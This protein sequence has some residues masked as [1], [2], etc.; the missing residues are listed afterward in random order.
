MKQKSLT[1]HART[2]E[3]PILEA[4]EFGFAYMLMRH[5]QLHKTYPLAYVEQLIEPALK[6][7]CLKFYF[8]EQGAPVGYAIWATVTDD[9]EE[10][11]MRSGRWQLHPSEWNE[12]ATLWLVDFVAPF[13]HA[14]AM[15]NDLARLLSDGHA[16]LRYFRVRHNRLRFGEVQ[17]GRLMDHFAENRNVA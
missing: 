8:D 16:M 5:S 15:L 2:A 7:K 12:G 9:V 13:G 4:C 14:R 17:L 11:F 6:H 3:G 10:R 1:V